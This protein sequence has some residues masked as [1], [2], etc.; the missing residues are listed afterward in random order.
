MLLG[1]AKKVPDL[2]I[3]VEVNP[4]HVK[5]MHA[6]SEYQL[7]G[8][9]VLG[10]GFGLNGYRG[11]LLYYK[12]DIS[13]SELDLSSSFAERLAVKLTFQL[14]NVLIVYRSPNSSLEN[15]EQLLHLLNEFSQPGAG[16]LIIGD[17]NL[18]DKI[19]RAHV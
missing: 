12:D 11:I 17:F 3:L 7:S 5:N 4:K 18:P 19:G 2:I 9:Y 10:S 14:M 6:I 1:S 13:I 16:F 15:D 8:Y